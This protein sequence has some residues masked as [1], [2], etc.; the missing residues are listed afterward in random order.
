MGSDSLAVLI[1]EGGGTR[2]LSGV[3]SVGFCLSAFSSLGSFARLQPAV[4]H[5][6]TREGFLPASGSCFFVVGCMNAK[7]VTPFSWGDLNV[8]ESFLPVSEGVTKVEGFSYRA[9]SLFDLES[10]GRLAQ[11]CPAKRIDLGHFFEPSRQGSFFFWRHPWVRGQVVGLS[12]V[13]QFD[14]HHGSTRSS[15]CTRLA[16]MKAKADRLFVLSHLGAVD[17][18]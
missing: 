12:L 13:M 1:A 10:T 16:P 11:I 15:R 3:L 4:T 2:G 18:A 8:C 7:H 14:A 5:E 6:R 9:P 17:S